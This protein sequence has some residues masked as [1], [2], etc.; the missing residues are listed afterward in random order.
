MILIFK[1]T[2]FYFL[3]CIIYINIFILTYFT[4]NIYTK[5]VN[6]LFVF[7]I[8][9]FHGPATLAKEY[10]N[11]LNMM[12]KKHYI[13]KYF[14]FTIRSSV[15]FDYCK[16]YLNKSNSIIWFMFSYYFKEL[17]SNK[18][19][20][21]FKRIIYGPMVS[22]KKWLLFPMN[23][24][25]EVKWSIYISRIFAYVVQSERVKNHLISK[26][27][28]LKN[29]HKKYIVSHGCLMPNDLYSTRLWGERSID[30]LIYVKFADIN[31]ENELKHLIMSL[32]A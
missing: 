8:I 11:A 27:T 9:G 26:S 10:I 16:E 6:I 5:K 21:I 18:Y 4:S 31:Y 3:S 12:K 13:T 25:Y 30:I 2:I 28:K 22:P 1:N 29:I 14:T 24:T 15:S 17:I 23:N 32:R 19:C 7:P 20:K